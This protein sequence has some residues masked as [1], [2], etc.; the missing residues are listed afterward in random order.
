MELKQGLIQVYTGNGKGKSTASIGQGIRAAGRG[1]QVYMVQFLKSS[2]SGELHIIKNIDNFEVFRFERPRGFFWTL[3]D[4]EKLE[5]QEDIDKAM[6]FVKDRLESG[7][8]DLLIL[9]EVMGSIKNKLIDVDKLVSM[10]KNRKPHMEVVLTG[11][12][13]PAE[14][15]EI[16]DYVSEINPIKHPFEKGIPAR[17]GIED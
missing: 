12:N 3:N 6:Q 4:K 9:D 5:L 17:R 13:V 11:R 1:L 8:C 14:I 16:A 15:V 10:L 2:D 7:D